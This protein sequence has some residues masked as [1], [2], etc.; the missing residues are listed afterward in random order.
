MDLDHVFLFVPSRACAERR[1]A[2]AGLRATFSRVHPGQGTTNLCAFLDDMFIELLWLDG[3]APSQATQDLGLI[4]R[5]R[6][7]GLPLGLAW[8]GASSTPTFGYA[9]PYLPAGKTIAVARASRDPQ[10]PLLFQSPA[11]AAPV[12]LPKEQVGNRQ[13]PELTTLRGCQIGLQDRDA[14]KRALA[15]FARVTV[16]PSPRPYV[17]FEI[18]RA[19]SSAPKVVT[20]FWDQPR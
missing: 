17:R 9:A 1:F 11:Q 20:W 19:R 2:A 8:R 15:A 12:H 7:K 18:N 3:S 5:A 14:A 10:V 4:D 16:R 13:G 6:G